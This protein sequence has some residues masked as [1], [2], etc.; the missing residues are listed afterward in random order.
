MMDT[1][2]S[3]NFFPVP[4]AISKAKVSTRQ[5]SSTKVVSLPVQIMK[6]EEAL[7]VEGVTV[8]LY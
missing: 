8:S 4:Y 6:L 3:F 5:H 1:V 2:Y 7:Q